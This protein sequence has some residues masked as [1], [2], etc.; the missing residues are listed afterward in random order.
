MT[1][2]FSILFTSAGRRVSLV[3][4]FKQALTDLGLPGKVVTADLKPNAPAHFVADAHELVPSVTDP[5]YL[6]RV[7]TICREHGVRLVVPLTDTELHLLAPH[8]EAFQ[9][10]GVTLLVSSPEAVEIARDKR[11]TH[12]FF[13]RAGIPTPRLLNPDELLEEAPSVFPVLLKP[14][15]GSASAGVTKIRNARELAFFKDYVPNAIVQE[16]VC[17]AEYTLDILVDFAGRIRCVVPRLRIETRAGEVSK[18]MTVKNPTIIA[19]GKRVG[20]CLPGAVG[21][22]TVQCFLAED[23]ELSFIEIN[24][25]FGGGFPLSAEAGAN[26]ARWIIEWLLGRDPAVVLDGWRDGVVMLRYDAEVFTTREAV[27]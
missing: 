20:E 18:G 4:L 7:A 2:A 6:G 25:R 26:F 27:E 3:R 11:N 22:L 5:D 24:P 1:A 9:K 17:G 14:A 13:R 12:D 21:C 23:G 15:D 8:R 19:A 10:L 16:F